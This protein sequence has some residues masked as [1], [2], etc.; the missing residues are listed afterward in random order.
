MHA[1]ACESFLSENK[2]GFP[3][4]HRRARTSSPKFPEKQTSQLTP[5]N[6]SN[7]LREEFLARRR[8]QKSLAPQ[9]IP[10]PNELPKANVGEAREII[11]QKIIETLKEFPEK[12]LFL[13]TSSCGRGNNNNNLIIISAADSSEELQQKK[14]RKRS[15]TK[16]KLGTRKRS[17][18]RVGSDEN[19]R[20][21]KEKKKNQFND[22]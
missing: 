17:R 11:N 20:N 16:H 19:N 22:V 15:G 21:L 7:Y 5:A 8:V 14:I 2:N 13:V 3:T 4:L 12:S 6:R 1:S 9:N 10:R 18:G